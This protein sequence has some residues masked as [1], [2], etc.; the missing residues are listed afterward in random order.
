MTM[1]DKREQHV[2]PDATLGAESGEGFLNRWSRRKREARAA[3]GPPSQAALPDNAPASAPEDSASRYVELTDD[4]MPPLESLNEHSDYR[5]FLSPKV[6][7]GLRRAALRKLFG[8]PRFNVCDGLDDYA[9]DFTSFEP[10]GDLVTH[11][12][13]RLLAREGEKLAEAL[14]QGDASGQTDQAP[15]LAAANERSVQAPDIDPSLESAPVEPEGLAAAERGADVVR[16][17]SKQ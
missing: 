8:Q 13:H 4:D 7:E 1:S 12:M 10:L 16:D 17:G 15:R 6:S 14:E 5:G 2:E 3:D 11:E 9:E